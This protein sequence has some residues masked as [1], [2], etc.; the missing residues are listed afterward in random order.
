MPRQA[1][2]IDVFSAASAITGLHIQGNSVADQVYGVWVSSHVQQPAI[3]GNRAE[4]QV[5]TLVK[6]ASATAAAH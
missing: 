1:T 6:T 3:F 4:G 5:G 2:G